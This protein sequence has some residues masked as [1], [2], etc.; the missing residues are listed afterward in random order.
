MCPLI[1]AS[2]SA[3]AVLDGKQDVT[4]QRKLQN[5]SPS[6]GRHCA[7]EVGLRSSTVDF[8]PLH[9]PTTPQT[10]GSHCQE[11]VIKFSSK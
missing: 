5:K 9:L 6:E 10:S 11:F 7:E 3:A 4:N 2:G 1:K 8:G